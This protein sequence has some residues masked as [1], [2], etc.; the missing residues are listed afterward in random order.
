MQYKLQ[1]LIIGGLIGG[2]AGIVDLLDLGG[3]DP[4]GFRPEVTFFAYTALI[5]GGAATPLG[6][7]V[8]AMLFWFL[9]QGTESAFR[10]LAGQDWPPDWFADFLNGREGLL[11]TTLLGVA[12]VVLMIFRPQGLFGSRQEMVLGD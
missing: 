2:L 5:M 11:A 6:P 10:D 3:T 1:A 7:I 8:G 9:R 12:L 4:V